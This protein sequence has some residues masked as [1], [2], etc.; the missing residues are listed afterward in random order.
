[1]AIKKINEASL[2]K[3]FN[4]F[5]E[6]I[7]ERVTDIFGEEYELEISKHFKKS[8]TQ[9]IMIDYLEIEEEFKEIKDIESLKD[10]II[11]PMLMIKQFTNISIPDEGERLLS[12]ANKLVE[13]ELLNKI[14]DILPEDELLKMTEVADQFKNVVVKMVEEKEK[15][16]TKE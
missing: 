14:L 3:G 8:D 7:T 13:L 16:S 10:T 6:K 9:K 12:M 5:N 11:I 1:M 4:K 2:N 15:E